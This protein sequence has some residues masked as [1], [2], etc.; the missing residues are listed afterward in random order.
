M[1]YRFPIIYWNTANL[2][3]DSGSLEGN[4][5]TTN[6]GKI[7]T[8]IGKF[9][10]T[11]TTVEVPDIN[12]SGFG[13]KPDEKE[14]IILFGLKGISGIGDAEAQAIISNR[15]YTSLDN[16]LEKIEHYKSLSKENKFGES[17]VI[18]LIKAGAFDHL[19]NK[20]REEIMSDYIR[21]ISKPL[22]SLQLDS[23]LTLNELDLLTDEQKQYELRL[24]KFRKYIFQSQF[25]REK[26]GKSANTYFYQLDQRFAEPFFF[27]YFETNMQE[28]KDYKY[29]DQG[30]IL[31]KR[32]SIDREF[33][34]MMKPFKE[35]ILKDPKILEAINNQRF[36]TKWNEK[37]DGNIS[38]WE[39]DSLSFYYHEHEL[40]HVN[41]EQYL[42]SDFSTLPEKPQISEYYQ[43]RGKAK[44]R[45]KLTRIC[46]TVLDKDKNKH[47]ITLLTPSGVVT[48]K[49]YKGQF[50]FYDKQISELNEDGSKTVLEKSWFGR[51]NK[52]LVTGYRR[53]DQFVP[54]KY[55][56]SAYRH[57]L[58]LITDI[59]ENGNLKLQSERVGENDEF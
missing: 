41:K 29:D 11:G 49:F 53:E 14:N 59:D 58:Q 16:F 3:V 45:F 18:T 39:M 38:K 28:D 54:K 47:M 15:P 57:T 12:D 22:N 26:A 31:V 8:A 4:K 46:G 50:S 17:A 36:I 23:I 32:G 6:Y 2:I 19:E 24:V 9:Q 30:Y 10:N 20:K 1:C 44:P 52:L 35:N 43:Y 33:E 21:K 48:I 34:K 51:G 56:D 40:A 55:V 7:A 13:F 37:V 25:L 42:I 27:E 5:K